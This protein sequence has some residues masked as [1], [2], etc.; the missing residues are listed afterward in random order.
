VSLSRRSAAAAIVA[1]TVAL[2]GG[3]ALA[4]PEDPTTE[5]DAVLE[6][7]TGDVTGTEDG[8]AVGGED[9][10]T[11][12]TEGEEADSHGALVSEAAHEHAYDEACGN[13]GK[14][15]SAVARTGEQPECATEASEEGG[16]SATTDDGSTD[17]ATATSSDA[18]KGK[19][20][21]KAK[22]RTSRGR[23]RG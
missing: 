18:G 8:S 20:K 16:E 2:G 5:G 10:A 11:E 15:V 21:A 4:S 9:E 14:Y 23:G 19:G 1:M 6:E 13:H 22:T 7:P 3:L 17:T 12:G